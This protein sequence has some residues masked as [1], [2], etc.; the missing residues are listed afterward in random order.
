MV[1][2][3]VTVEESETMVAGAILQQ[4]A[5]IRAGKVDPQKVH[6][7][8]VPWSVDNQLTR[9]FWALREIARPGKPPPAPARIAAPAE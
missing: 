1:E 7:K 8:I 9:L 4:W 3:G 2:R 6:E 5:D